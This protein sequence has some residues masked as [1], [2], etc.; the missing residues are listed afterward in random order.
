VDVA[1]TSSQIFSTLYA[2]AVEPANMAVASPV[3]IEKQ[4]DFSRSVSMFEK[5]SV[6]TCKGQL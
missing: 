1:G 5:K 3:K 4:S 2:Q 6:I